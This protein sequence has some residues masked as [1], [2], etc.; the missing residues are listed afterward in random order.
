MDEY[1]QTAEPVKPPF[2]FRSPMFRVGDRVRI[3]YLSGISPRYMDHFE[4]A[5]GVIVCVI[6]CKS[7]GRTILYGVQFDKETFGATG[8]RCKAFELDRIV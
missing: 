5:I 4:G 8:C 6:F 3:V 2:G 7:D 1:N